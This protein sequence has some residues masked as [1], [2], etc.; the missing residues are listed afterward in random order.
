MGQQYEFSYSN[1]TVCCIHSNSGGNVIFEC[2]GMNGSYQYQYMTY[3]FV[4]I[5][6][7]CQKYPEFTW[8][9][10]VLVIADT[11]RQFEIAF[12]C[13]YQLKTGLANAVCFCV[14]SHSKSATR[15][16]HFIFCFALKTRI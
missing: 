15:N 2:E 10:D 7:D 12:V 6:I 1:G 8:F 3:S 11:M 16:F 4:N 5:N 14:A 9:G 13:E